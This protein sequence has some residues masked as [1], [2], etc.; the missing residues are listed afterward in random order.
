MVSIENRTSYMV[1]VSE[2]LKLKAFHLFLLDKDISFVFNNNLS[3][4]DELFFKILFAIRT[5]NKTAFDEIYQKKS[6]SKPSKDSPTPFV[7]DDY[8]IFSLII[9]ICKFN[10]EKTWINYIISVRNRNVTTITFENILNQNYLSTSNLTEVVLVFLKLY[11]ESKISNDLLNTSLKSITENANLLENRSDFQILCAFTAYD[12]IIYQKEASEGNEIAALKKFNK[13]FIMRI[14]ILSWIF[15]A[16]IFLALI[17]GLFKLPIYTPKVVSFLEK[18]DYIF[19]LLGVSGF[20]FLG[21]RIP[22]IKNKSHYFLMKIFG[23][24]EEL[25]NVR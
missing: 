17:Y 7:N 18:Y 4:S 3:D 8:L 11:N 19:T 10:I 14:K 24:P 25:I 13:E 20:T 15:Q 12:L 22:F 9:G 23:Y 16:G 5:N 6:K 21:N 2:S 1:R